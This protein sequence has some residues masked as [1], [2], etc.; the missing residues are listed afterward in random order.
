MCWKSVCFVLYSN[1]TINKYVSTSACITDLMGVSS[2]ATVKKI[3]KIIGIVLTLL[4][5]A[6][7]VIVKIYAINLMSGMKRE[8][9]PVEVVEIGENTPDTLHDYGNCVGELPWGVERTDSD[10]EDIYFNADKGIILLYTEIDRVNSITGEDNH[11]YESIYNSML[12]S[13]ALDNILEENNISSGEDLICYLHSFDSSNISMKYLFKPMVDI[14]RTF[15]VCAL[16]NG[17]PE[18]VEKV[19]DVRNDRIRS[20]VAIYRMEGVMMIDIRVVSLSTKDEVLFTV[21]NKG[22]NLTEEDI[23]NFISTISFKEQ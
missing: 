4:V 18:D 2:M 3:A 1:C 12:E 17:L 9:V 21:N 22:N 6:L 19:Y 5:V 11:I 13:N 14:Y 8:P 16:Q 7:Y 20:I 15:F 10:F 23:F